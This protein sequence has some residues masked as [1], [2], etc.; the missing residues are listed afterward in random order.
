LTKH[1]RYTW[2]SLPY[3][4]YGL[5]PPVDAVLVIHSLNKNGQIYQVLT[6]KT[7]KKLYKKNWRKCWQ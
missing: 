4:T 2:Y 7:L 1:L 3:F 5:K 6:Q